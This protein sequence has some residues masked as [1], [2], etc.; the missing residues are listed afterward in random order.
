MKKLI[1]AIFI[2]TIFTYSQVTPNLPNG[3]V[4]EGFE[5]I[6]D[7]TLDGDEVYNSSDIIHSEGS[8][9]IKLGTTAN[10]H[11]SMTKT[12]SL[13]LNDYETFSIDVYTPD[14]SSDLRRSIR[15]DISSSSSFNT[16]FHAFIYMGNRIYIGWNRLYFSK[17]DF[18]N[19]NGGESW[20][21]TMIK[22]SFT[23]QMELN[24]SYVPSFITFDNFIGYKNKPTAIAIIT[25]DDNER[26][27][28]T[29]GK[30]I[31]DALGFKGVQFVIGSTADAMSQDYLNW[32]DYDQLYQ[33][34]WDVSNHTYSHPLLTTLDDNNLELEINGMRDILLS[35]GYT[36][37]ADFFAYPYGNFNLNV[38]NK[39]KEHNKLARGVNDWQYSAHPSSELGDY[40]LLRSHEES[41]DIQM[42][43]SDIDLAISR[44]QLLVYL[45]HDIS[46]YTQKF[47]DIMTYLKLK[48]D[49]G[50]I[51]VM[52][53]SEY[54]NYINSVTVGVNFSLKV[55][56]QGPYNVNNSIMNTGLP[57]P[58]ISPYSDNRNV[59]LIPNNI[60]DWVYVE[61]RTS[62]SGP[63]L[64]ARSAFLRNDGLIVGDDGVSDL[65]F[66]VAPG[67]HY[68][69]VKHRNH[70]GIMSSAPIN[71]SA[72]STLYDFTTGQTKAYTID[73]AP[74][75]DLTNGKFGLIAGD[76]N[77]DGLI[78]HSNDIL[79]QWYPNLGQNGYISSDFNLDGTVDFTNDISKWLLN[80]GKSTQ[81]PSFS[82]SSALT[83]ELKLEVK[84]LK[85]ANIKNSQVS[86][87]SCQSYLDKKMA[88]EK[89]FESK[90]KNL[91]EKDNIIPS[92]F[93]LSQNYPNPF[94]PS[95]TIQYGLVEE[96][97][98]TLNLYNS[99][100]EK[101][102]T[103]VQGRESPGT[104]TQRI[105]GTNLSSGTYI[106]NIVAEGSTG[107]KNKSIKIILLK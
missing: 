93:F 21:N 25:F 37:S 38:I 53:M 28:L 85:K 16:Y 49:A 65:Y 67:N 89:N 45:F 35:H 44:G 71:L 3:E 87:E 84:T 58:L 75:I 22:I 1:C 82:I 91:S 61:L 43:Y 83:N 5:N 90:S 64:S 42:Q 4:V 70:L 46:G 2:A 79:A 50:L 88:S 94:N 66:P 14:F 26:S 99:L 101:I 78:D 24:D 13:N 74:M 33:E 56:L 19:V 34:G 68:V 23:E 103:F 17:S 48:Q 40:Y 47:S 98:V 7:W 106:L 54:W 27:T 60:V 52:T 77:G 51:K 32:N 39:V 41:E 18:V 29:Q 12:V 31:L 10:D 9:S 80:V 15:I 95:T 36:R 92:S 76:G 30:P 86:I 105:E 73:S 100:G 20:A 69:I 102:N 55:F 59:S 81:I 104:Y 11:P 63:T 107:V 96:S 8:N 72:T 57:V 62:S 97:F 6:S